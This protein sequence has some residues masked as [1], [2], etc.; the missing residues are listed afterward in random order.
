MDN[1]QQLT[2]LQQLKESRKQL[3][4]VFALLYKAKF[5]GG[6]S[7]AVFQALKYVDNT[8]GE[9]NKLI[10]SLEPKQ[11]TSPEAVKADDIN[12]TAPAVEATVPATEAVT[13]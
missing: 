10:A 13:K 6:Q 5:E 1:A 12:G 11:T 8:V 2:Q 4:N 3:T 9:L 7:E